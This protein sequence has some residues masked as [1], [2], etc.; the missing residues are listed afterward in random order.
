MTAYKITTLPVYSK[1][2]DEAEVKALGLWEKLPEKEDGSRWQLSQHQVETYK[3][4]TSEDCDVVF[5][6]A[7]TGD[8]KSLAGQLPILIQGGINW[9]TLAMYPTNELIADQYTNFSQTKERWKADVEFNPLNSSELD[10]KFEDE[11]YQRRGDALMSLLKNN[12]LLLGN[13]DIFHYLMHQFYTFQSDAPDRYSAPLTQKIR[14]LTFD[15]FHIFDAPQIVS[16]LNALLFMREI[17]GDVRPHKILFLSATPGVLMLQYLRRSGLKVRDINGEYA[18]SGNPEAWRRILYPAEI[19]LEPE[20]RAET[21]IEQHLETTLLPFFLERK[22]NAKGAIIVNSVAS[23][24]RIFEK[25]K[26]VFEKH[27]LTAELNTGLTSHSRRKASYEADLLIGTSTVDVGV[28]FQIN[29]LL[30]ESRDSGSFL[31]RLGR[32][33]R[34]EGYKRNGQTHKFQN[35]VAYALVPNWIAERLFKGKEGI[36]A[37][38]IADTTI[39]REQFNQAI[40]EAYPPVATFDQYARC[41][42]QFQTI[43]ILWGMGRAPV[44]EQYKETIVKLQKRYEETFN[45]HFAFG[46][47]KELA[48]SQSPLLEDALSFRG[49]DEFPCCVIDDD[50]TEAKGPESFKNTDLLQ[51]VA[52]Y[53]LDYLSPGVFY[54]EVEKVGLKKSVFEGRKPL[55]FF[56]LRGVGI[57]RQNFKFFLDKDLLYWG[58]EKF[59]KAEAIKGFRLDA[60]FPGSTEINNRLQLREIPA[61]LISEKHPLD[62]KRQLGLPLLFPL[63]EFASR[64]GVTGTVAF[65]RTALMLESRLLFNAMP[66]G[67]GA[68]VV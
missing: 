61:L 51:M 62:V 10:R 58:A 12:D 14:Q 65:G 7:M 36:P 43:K 25:I 4:L 8:G 67:G 41:W 28:D 3:A 2:A 45:L 52:N 9:S 57:E 32:L 46:R 6:T 53:N 29:F 5:N 38:L 33:G 22:P 50:E 34:H 13:P 19:N 64:D 39:D 63:H 68:I 24:Y 31:Q 20:P 55:G 42:G 44:R 18:T 40:G 35:Y 48:K 37:S 47:Y 66:T 16:V 49:G 21:W 26:P 17:G 30:F 27:G 56:R 54:A 1:L 59:G 15:E 11:N 23:A 60:N